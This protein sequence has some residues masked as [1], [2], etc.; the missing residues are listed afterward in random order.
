MLLLWT[1]RTIAP[2]LHGQSLRINLGKA[3]FFK[4][5]RLQSK[6]ENLSH[7][8]LRGFFKSRFHQ[9]LADALFIIGYINFVAIIYL[10][11]I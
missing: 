11:Y 10:L 5:L 4:K 3:Q 7:T 8:Y 9:F 2:D 1:S 6:G